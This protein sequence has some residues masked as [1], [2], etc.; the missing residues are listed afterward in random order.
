M[1][2][3]SQ[4]LLW[5]V[6]PVTLLVAST[7]LAALL[8][9]KALA[10]VYPLTIVAALIAAS[11]DAFAMVAGGASTGSLPLGLPAI[12]LHFRLDALSG[13]FGI[14]V[15]VGAVGAALYGMGLDRKHEVSPRIE[16]FFALFIAAMNVV[17]LADDA[18]SFLFFWELMSV[19]S[20]LLVLARH[21]E[22]ETRRAAHIYLV[23]ASIG[24][25]AL[26]F[27]FGGMAGPAGSYTFD[28]IRATRLDPAIASLVLFAAFVGTSSKAGIMP[29]HAWLP[30]AHPAAPSHVSALM[31]GVMTKVAV[32]GLL[33]IVFDLLGAPSW[34]WSLP[35]I[36]LGALTAVGALLYALMDTDL[37]RV[38]AYSTIENIG[39]IYVGIG[40][41][42]AFG[43]TGQ[44]AAAAVAM[45]AALLHAIYHSWY[46]SLLF[47]GAGAVQHATGSRNLDSL[48]GLIHRMPRTAVMFLVGALAISA[49]PPLN[50]FVSEWLLFQAVL[51]G[52]DLPEPVLRFLTP[53]VGGLLAL[54]AALAAACFVRVYGIVFLGRPRSNDAAG[55]HEVP[56]LQVQAMGFLAVLCV[57]GGLL[58]GVAVAAIGPVIDLVVGARLPGLNT[59]PTPLSLV[60]FE[61]ARSIYDAVT[62]AGFVA[63]AATLTALL[64]HWISDRRTR[65]GPAWDCGFPNPSPLT[66]YSASSFAQP[67]RRVYGSTAFSARETI[68]MPRPGEQRAARI[69]VRLTDHLWNVFYAAPAGAVSGMASKLNRLQFLTIRRYLV[70]M[71][72]ALIIL[73]LVTA[74]RS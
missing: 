59:G 51:A 58:G 32:Y 7:T 5:M 43:A 74:V 64:L 38:L 39:I 35:F 44:A 29:L 55:A 33:R 10:L 21:E 14:V 6:L 17:L 19:T 57:A 15:N 24:T 31:S 53:V 47:L 72:A 23:M 4:L 49:L 46:K 69:D 62:I 9:G 40:L 41:S 66:Q 20:W 56:R 2:D 16:P 18:Y 1:T 11:I 50:G 60:A 37:K 70:L 52:P 45:T 48:G 8:R 61:S 28:A 25:I 63:I 42:L 65:R 27:A 22:G 30:L 13:F 3:A 68:D 54:A 67:L 36:I 34:W 12:G 71:F 73:L 26:L